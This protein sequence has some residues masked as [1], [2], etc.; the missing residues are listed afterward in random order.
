MDIGINRLHCVMWVCLCS[1]RH[2]HCSGSTVM[3]LLCIP[4]SELVSFAFSTIQICPF[5]FIEVCLQLSTTL[6]VPIMNHSFV[7]RAETMH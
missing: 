1:T 4:V 6:E 3:A 2:I 5:L 7:T